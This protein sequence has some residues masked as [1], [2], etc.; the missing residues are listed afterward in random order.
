M[1]KK[2]FVSLPMHGRSEEEILK[3][4]KEALKD[5]QDH[6]I[7]KDDEYELMET[8]SGDPEKSRLWHLGRAIQRLDD[9]DVVYFDYGW[10]KAKGCWVEFIACLMYDKFFEY[11]YTSNLA[12]GEIETAIRFFERIKNRGDATNVSED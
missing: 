3:A 9:A 12:L 1:K 2:V 11:T 7:E 5:L 8:V 6:P 10:H 4:Q